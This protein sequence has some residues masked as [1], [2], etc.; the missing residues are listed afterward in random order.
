MHV[1]GLTLNGSAV[2]ADDTRLQLTTGG[3]N[4]AG[5]VFWNT[6]V[7]VQSFSTDFNFQ[8]SGSSSEKMKLVAADP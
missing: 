3:T 7:G 1:A 4:Q 8:L 6:P 5:S 2:N